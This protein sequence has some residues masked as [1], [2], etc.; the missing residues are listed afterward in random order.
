[1]TKTQLFVDDCDVTPCD[2]CF[3]APY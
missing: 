3:R 2:C 1:L